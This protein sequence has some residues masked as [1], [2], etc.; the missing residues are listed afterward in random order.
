MSG[1]GALLS[2][3][4][5]DS[6]PRNDD[7]MTAQSGEQANRTS[8][9]AADTT[10]ESRTTQEPTSF[11]DA[12]TDFKTVGGEKQPTTGG[13]DSL[14]DD[15]GNVD[16]GDKQAKLIVTSLPIMN[17]KIGRFQFTRGVLN[18]FEDKDVTDFRALVKTLPPADRNQLKIVDREAAEAMVRPIEPGATKQFDSSV[19]RHG[20][21]IGGGETVGTK[22]LDP[23]V[24]GQGEQF[25]KRAQQ[26]NNVP[27]A[28]TEPKHVVTDSNGGDV[29]SQEAIDQQK[30]VDEL[31]DGKP[32]D[33]A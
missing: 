6:A 15:D 33:Q 12:G 27:V 9:V 4:N 26:N 22:P 8:E 2:R 5:G 11:A 31:A 25:V 21:T 16:E 17:F 10:T 32:V 28:G 13:I 3:G 19:G 24:G 1:L 7:S 18:L 30:K 29:Q 14:F 20:D 23:G